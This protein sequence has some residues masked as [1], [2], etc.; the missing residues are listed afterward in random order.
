MK[1]DNTQY[2][3][4][5][6][7]ALLAYFGVLRPILKKFGFA[8]TQETNNVNTAQ[9]ASADVN[10]FAPGYYKTVI[11]KNPNVPILLKT[12][13]GLEKIYKIF[14]DGFGYI[15]DDE[16]KITSAFV[17]LASKVQVSQFSEYVQRKTGVDIITFMRNGIN[18]VNS[19]SGLNDTE[20][21][22]IIQIVNNKPTF[23]K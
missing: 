23:T 22:R 7:I 12:Q 4:Y 14:Y 15:Y 13:S 1:K 6:G 10:P 3:I 2:F 21:N 17:M 8:T 11:Q 20:I 5:G 9:T 18:S 19:A 16:N